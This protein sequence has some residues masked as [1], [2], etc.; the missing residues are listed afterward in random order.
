MATTKKIQPV[1]T[2]K[3]DQGREVRT[4]WGSKAHKE[5]L[6]TQKAEKTTT[7]TTTTEKKK[8]PCPGRHG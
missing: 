5:H 8:P 3:D 1:Y 2:Y 6:A 4:A 7:K